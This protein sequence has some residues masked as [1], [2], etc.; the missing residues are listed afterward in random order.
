MKL[1]K[2]RERQKKR[3]RVREI[4]RKSKKSKRKKGK[5]FESFFLSFFL[6]LSFSFFL[7][8]TYA[9]KKVKL[10]FIIIIVF[11]PSKMRKH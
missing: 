9:L 2:K 11:T 1:N 10:L 6:P 5:N 8:K 7:S 3:K 4:E